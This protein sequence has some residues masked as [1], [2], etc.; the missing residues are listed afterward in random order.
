MAFIGVR[1]SCDIFAKKLD[2]AFT[3]SSAKD[4]A[5][6]RVSSAIFCS[7]ISTNV[8]NKPAE[9]PSAFTK[10]FTQYIVVCS[11]PSP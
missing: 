5:S 6:A 4:L 11:N 2:L 9:E 7:L 10:L 8:P 3:A 1:I